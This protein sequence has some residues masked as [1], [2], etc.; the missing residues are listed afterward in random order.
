MTLQENFKPMTGKRTLLIIGLVFPEPDT[1]A[2][3]VRMMQLISYFQSKGFEITFVT[4]AA[5]SIYAVDLKKLQV[6]IET[7]ELNNPSFD[8]MIKSLKP[9]WVLYDRF[10]T[11]E[12]FGWRVREKCPEAVN[13]MDTE[14]LHF[15]REARRHSKHIQGAHTLQ[16]LTNEKTKREIASIYRCDLSLIISEFEIKLLKDTFRIPSTLLFYL[17]LLVDKSSLSGNSVDQTEF[18]KREHFMCIGNLKHA[19]NKDAIIYL[20]ESIWPLIRKKLPEAEL[21]I[22]GAYADRS[23]LNLQNEASGFLLK[24]WAPDKQQ[25]FSSYRVCLA[26]LRFGAGLK[27]KLLD[28]MLYGLPS[29]TTQIGAEGIEAKEKW[30]GFVCDGHEDIAEKSV[31]LYQDPGIWQQAV[32]NG[33]EIL[34]SGF[35]KDNFYREF[36]LQLDEMELRIEQHRAENFIGAMLRHH[37]LQSTKYLS[38]WIEAKNAKN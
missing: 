33:F 38:K 34:R 1:T 8:E 15:L 25:V 31:L 18:E 2:A 21:H 3:G 36:S 19:P 35:D 16:F 23:T 4:T 5:S 29:V 30:N 20:K 7:I 9:G 24:G 22:Y 13:I 26:P 14:D 10:V 28:S 11:E 27:G 17:P 32:I 12:Q 37:N 6:K